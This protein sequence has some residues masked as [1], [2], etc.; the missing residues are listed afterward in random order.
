M[1]IKELKKCKFI[2]TDLNGDNVVDGSDYLIGDNNGFNYVVI[3][4]P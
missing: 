1:V 4:R 2:S 3:I